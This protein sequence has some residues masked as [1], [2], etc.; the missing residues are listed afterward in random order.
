MI[1]NK[2]NCISDSIHFLFFFFFCSSFCCNNSETSP[3]K[4]SY[5]CECN[6]VTI[7]LLLLSFS[8]ACLL[9]DDF[10][11]KKLRNLPLNQQKDQSISSLVRLAF[12][13]INLCNRNGPF[14]ILVISILFFLFGW[15][16]SVILKHGLSNIEWWP[17]DSHWHE[18]CMTSI[19]YRTLCVFCVN[20]MRPAT[21]HDSFLHIWRNDSLHLDRFEFIQI[22][23]FNP[24]KFSEHITMWNKWVCIRLCQHL[25]R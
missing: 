21:I 17:W 5:I 9:K 4:N 3:K 19:K 25:Y 2:K 13:W 15:N 11:T 6:F 10:D 14:N 23:I 20:L 8:T 22:K 24:N 12:V 16:R 7:C 18:P 1:D